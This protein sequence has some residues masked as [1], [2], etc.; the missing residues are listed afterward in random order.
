MLSIGFVDL[1]AVSPTFI[2]FTKRTKPEQPGSLRFEAFILGLITL[3]MGGYKRI[4]IPVF[5]SQEEGRYSTL[6]MAP[7]GVSEHVCEQK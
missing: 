1:I 3:G 7:V 4:I 2:H 5:G 6:I